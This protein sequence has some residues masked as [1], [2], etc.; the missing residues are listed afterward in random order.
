MDNPALHNPQFEGSTFFWESGPTGVLLLHGLTATT[1]EVRMLAR[2][3]YGWG[4]TLSGPLL[5]GH[6]TTPGEL[7]R[8][9]WTDWA[10]AAEEAYQKLRANCRR[11][12]VGGE[13]MGAVL[14]LFL[15]SE[16]PEISGVMCYAPALKLALQPLQVMQ[17]YL[18]APFMLSVPKGSID[19]SQNWQGYPV[20][21]LKAGIELL[22]LEKEV[23]R[24]LSRIEQPILVVEG[25]LDTTIDLTSADLIC[26][27]VRSTIKSQHMMEN[28][29][30]V[31]LLDSELDQISAL[32]LNFMQLAG[33]DSK[34]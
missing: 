33:Q 4:Y 7:N 21:P 28:S 32:T 16:H 29:S 25:R 34:A 6:G 17:M 3:L 18:A 5:P 2:H 26:Q 12:F 1:S 15:A 11:V 10:L 20:N 23:T 13:S 19:V 8:T 9:R 30:H 14:A 31:V 22:K 27:G 24:R